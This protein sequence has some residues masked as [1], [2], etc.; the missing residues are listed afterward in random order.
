[1]A[2]RLE[3]VEYRLDQVQY[4]C[5]QDLKRGV[6]GAIPKGLVLQDLLLCLLCLASTLATQV[7]QIK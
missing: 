5:H 1:M 3:T 7:P 6:C 2:L 4:E